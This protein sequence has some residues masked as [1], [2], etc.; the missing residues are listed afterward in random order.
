MRIVSLLPAATEMVYLL[1]LDQHLVGVSHECDFPSEAG[2]KPR[3]TRTSVDASLAGDEINSQVDRLRHGHRSLYDLDV[4]KIRSLKPDLIL[5]QEICEVCAVSRSQVEEAALELYGTV[6]VVSFEPS[7]LEGVLRDISYLGELTGRMEAAGSATARLR[8][9]ISHIARQPSSNGESVVVLEW[10]RPPMAA[11]HWIPEMIEMSGGRDAIMKSGE[12][13]RRVEWDEVRRAQPDVLIIAPCG[14]S[15]SK[16]VD[17]Y[18]ATTLAPWWNELPA[19]RSG[20]VFAIDGNSYTSR[21]G[22]RLVDALEMIATVVT[23]RT[24]TSATYGVDYARIVSRI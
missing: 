3:L 1:G 8:Q 6:N 15:L 19:V 4:E 22:P 20:R 12:K 2:L 14:Y 9:R 5:T 24:L 17:E 16:A 23:G 13:S 21:P 18:R 10:L 11:G 7:T